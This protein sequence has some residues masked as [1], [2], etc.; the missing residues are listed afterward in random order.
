MTPAQ[1]F[2]CLAGVSDEGKCALAKAYGEGH[3][4]LRRI[5]CEALLDENKSH[6][7]TPLQRFRLL[8][9][10]CTNRTSAASNAFLEGQAGPM[11]VFCDIFLNEDNPTS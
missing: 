6:A 1:I 11:Q 3:A 10:T 2:D 4:E 8:F 5:F 9:G 7:L